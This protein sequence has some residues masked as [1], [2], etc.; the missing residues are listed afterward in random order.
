[1]TTGKAIC[2]VGLAA[3]S[4]YKYTHHQDGSGWAFVAFLVLLL[5]S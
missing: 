5:A 2:V 1:M 4:A 3:V